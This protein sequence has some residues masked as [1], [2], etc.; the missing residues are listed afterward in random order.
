MF[1]VG[2]E[3]GGDGEFLVQHFAD[4]GDA[5]AA[6]DEQDAAELGGFD[7]GGAQRPGHGGDGFGQGGAD[8]RFELGAGDA[9]GGAE[10]GEGDR[11]QGVDVGGEGFFGFDAVAAEPGQADGDVGVVGVQGGVG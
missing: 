4:E 8:H 7:V 11:D 3:G 6:A 10:S 5:G 2:V 1:G 9:D